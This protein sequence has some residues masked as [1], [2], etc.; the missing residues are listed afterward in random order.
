LI[1][2]IGAILLCEAAGAL[3]AIF[4]AKAIPAWYAGL[5]KPSLNPPNWIFGPVWTLLYALMGIALYRVWRLDP[6]TSGRSLGLSLF[7]TQ[8]ALNA[9]W[10]P[11][12]FGLRAFWWAFAEILLLLA[13]IAW[14][15]FQ[16][17]SLDTLSSWLLFPYLAWVCFAGWLNYA[18]AK[19]NP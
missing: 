9:L 14:T 19:L 11:L 7:F 5:R 17:Y 6:Q 4:T 3:G 10:T 1:N 16:F 8:L 15:T 13:A 18:Y 2:L 12:F